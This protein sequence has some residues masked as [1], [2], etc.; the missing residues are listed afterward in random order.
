MKYSFY[1]F[2]TLQVIKW[3]HFLSHLRPRT[4]GYIQWIRHR[5][6]PTLPLPNGDGTKATS[7]EYF[8]VYTKSKHWRILHLIMHQKYLV[9]FFFLAYKLSFL[10]LQLFIRVLTSSGNNQGAILFILRLF[11]SFSKISKIT[12]IYKIY[13]R[14]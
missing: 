7:P 12:W 10:R 13:R 3:G 11:L 2:G 4:S 8:I 9:Q 6:L 1:S 5:W 14:I